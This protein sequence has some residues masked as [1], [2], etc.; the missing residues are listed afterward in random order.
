MA[1]LDDCVK[2]MDALVSRFDSVSLDAHNFWKDNHSEIMERELQYMRKTN[3]SALQTIK[4][5]GSISK[6]K[7]TELRE[8]GLVYGRTISPQGEEYLRKGGEGWH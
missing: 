1:N 4:S 8:L 2:A 5:G 3:C 6:S 7:L